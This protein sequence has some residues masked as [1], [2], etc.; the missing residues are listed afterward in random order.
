MGFNPMVY[1]RLAEK[2]LR[3]R[4]SLKDSLLIL[5]SKTLTYFLLPKKMRMIN[6][7]ITEYQKKLDKL[8]TLIN[9]PSQT[10]KLKGIHF[11]YV[12]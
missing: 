12:R 7:R 4:V 9:T 3:K 1:A 10:N 2:A 6:A 5:K 8:E 11:N